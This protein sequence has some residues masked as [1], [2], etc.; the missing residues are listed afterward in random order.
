MTGTSLRLRSRASRTSL[1]QLP[2]RMRGRRLVRRAGSSLDASVSLSSAI[3]RGFSG[4]SR[5]G[6]PTAELSRQSLGGDEQSRSA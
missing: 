5:Q 1:A 3:S 6:V 2:L 4:R